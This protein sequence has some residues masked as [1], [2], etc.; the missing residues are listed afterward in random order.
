M[1]KGQ[2][3]AGTREPLMA[4]STPCSFVV[5]GFEEFKK[6]IV[7]AGELPVTRFTASFWTS[8]QRQGCSLHEISY[9]GCFKPEL[10]AFFI[11]RLTCPGDLVYDP[12]AGRGTTPVEAGLQG[13]MVAAND[14]NPLS[15]IMT[16]PRFFPP[17]T[18][19][20]AERL[21][22]V[23]FETG[24]EPSLDLSMFYH[25]KTLRELVSLR[26]YLL[27]RF[28]DGQADHLDA[29]I[30][31]IAT[32]RLTGHSKGFFSVYTL[33]PNQAVSPE[34]QRKINERLHQEPE[35]R[36]VRSIIT[37]KSAQ[38]VRSIPQ[39]GRALLNTAG[40]LGIFMNRDARN[41]VDLKDDSVSL[42]VTSPPFLDVVQYPKDNWIRCWFNGLDAEQIASRMTLTPTLSKWS[43]VM[44][45]VFDELYRVTRPGGHVAFEV[46]EVRNGRVKLDE[47]VVPL[48]AGAGFTCAGIL[49]NQQEFTKTS[50]I[51]GVSNNRTGTN[52]NRIVLL[53]KNTRSC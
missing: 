48:A 8:R 3:G 30:R 25:E 45:G 23:P 44:S 17:E 38:L 21:R 28:E 29:W 46:G 19:D 40:S 31:M 11:K 53:K 52:T 22:L 47:V 50:H 14:V 37:R 43:E 12:F 51:W 4:P 33:P 7:L 13:R 16:V 39:G 18:G 15:S 26:Q 24:V 1:P 32:N 36:D 6:D 10:P 20:L 27:C 49:V 41:T 9:R 2:A 42:T 35:Y 5:D 34:R